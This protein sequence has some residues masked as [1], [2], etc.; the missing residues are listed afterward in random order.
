MGTF[1]SR[2]EGISSHS[3]FFSRRAQSLLRTHLMKLGPPKIVHFLLTQIQLN[4]TTFEKLLHLCHMMYPNY[5]NEISPIYSVVYTQGRGLYRLYTLGD[6][7]LGSRL[8]ILSTTLPSIPKDRCKYK[9]AHHS[10]VGNMRTYC[11]SPKCPK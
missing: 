7:E 5:G 10:I 2:P 4:L 11:L 1:S 6:K 3:Y 9:V 8:R